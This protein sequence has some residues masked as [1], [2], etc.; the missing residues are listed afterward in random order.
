MPPK[1]N[2]SAST[3]M[4]GDWGVPAA[5]YQ[6]YNGGSPYDN[7][8]GSAIPIRVA[9]KAGG[10]QKLSLDDYLRSQQPTPPSGISDSEVSQVSSGVNT[11]R[12]RAMDST[13]SLSSLN[14]AL[15][16]L[17]ISPITEL[18]N[19]I[20]TATKL[21]EIREECEK[22]VDMIYEHGASAIHEWDIQQVL[23]TLSKP[24][25]PALIREGSMLLLQILSRKFAGRTPYEAYF[26]DLFAPA[27][28]LLADKENTVKRSAQASI[29]SLYGMFPVEAYSSVLLTM[30]LKYL[31]SSAKWQSKV[32]ALKTI[33]K[34]LQEAP[35]DLLESRFVDAIPVLTDMATDFKPE[36]AKVGYKS[37]NDFVKVLDNLDL[38][39]RYDLIV[40]TL[41]DPQKVPNC[42]RSLS[43]VTFVAEVT[44]PALALLVPILDKSFKLSSSSQ[45]QLRQTVMVTEN[46][47]RLVNNKFEIE[48]YI[49][50]LLP[51]V[52]RVVETASLPEVREL[53][54]KAL[55]VI[56]DA[57]AEQSDGKFHGRLSL[58]KAEEYLT[59]IKPKINDAVIYDYLV[60]ILLTD[61]NV[62]DWTRLTEY[63]SMS[64]GNFLDEDA[65]NTFVDK[66]IHKLRELFTPNVFDDSQ[67][68]GVV[69][70]N[71]DFSL[72][73]GTRLLLNKTNLR[74]VKGHRYGLCGRNGVGKSTL[75]RAIANGQLEGFPDK[76]EVRTCFVE[77]KLQGEEADMNL[78]DFI[79]SDPELKDASKEEIASALE[80]VGF[81]SERRNQQVG[82]LSGGW[83]MKLELARAMLMKADVLLL[84]EPTNH[85]DVTNVKWLEDYLVQHTNITS[86]IVS[87]DSRFLDT[88]CTDV[89]HYENKKLVYYKGNLSEFV[90]VKPEGKSYY[91]L[92]D[93]NVKMA[94]PPPGI[95]TGV[96]SNTR[97]VAR[98]SNVTFKYPSAEKP[99]LKNVSC[100]LSLSSRVAI[101]G[102]NGAGKSTL[103]KLLTGE[104]VPNE[105]TVEKHPNLRIGYIAQHALQHVN[106]HKEKTANQYLQWRYQFGDDREVLLKESRKIS[107]DSERQMLEKEIDIGD[108]RGKRQ[109]EAIVGRQKLKK[110]FQY[111]IKWKWW[112]PKYN[113]WVPREKLIAEGF[114]P[115]VQ[116]FDDHE[117]SREGLGYR[118]LTP[119]VIRKHF[120][121]V[122]LDGDIADH[123]PMGSLSGG[124]LVKVVIAG[125]MWNNPH[126]L[127][128]DEPT[129]YLDRDSLGGLAVA[130]REWSGGVVMISHNSEFVGALCPEQWIVEN[131]EMVK[132]G[133]TEIDQ[134]KFEDNGGESAQS[135]AAAEM[136]NKPAPLKKKDDDDSPA[137]IKVR[138]RKKKMTR[139]EKKAQE[140]RRRLRHLEWLSSPKGTPKP[141]DTDEEE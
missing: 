45:E 7:S 37:L 93:S 96:K 116:K 107:S 58:E 94:F 131:G 112:L 136:V 24:K 6:G 127:V 16:K 65:K 18:L 135:R 3:F 22:I 47:T 31:K 92:T 78:V 140:E 28:D 90:K 50:I 79:A 126:L 129:N 64:L 87:H 20:Q 53:A 101:L 42:I 25:N 39:P 10:K 84:D 11:P 74:L 83:K 60:K 4:P 46:L 141:V 8:T 72:A 130:I 61:S 125:A 51:G 133:V 40:Q 62:N 14:S 54:T 108:G 38:Q 48:H 89:I 95:L 102:P 134:S 121:D 103:I 132:K 86:L 119:S 88:V 21:S 113:S 56:E 63:L 104:L 33:D 81:N 137:N 100:S 124:Q 120:E 99:S 43:S 41:A 110:S 17:Q 2:P 12:G 66:T 138:T 32:G 91:T 114:E 57:Q 118:D 55:R 9:K 35:A 59:E 139:N 34:I 122:G 23:V 5:G 85:L 44:E 115:L 27:F 19:S 109:V 70:V 13:T 97:A 68:D 123:T 71:A 76:S 49:P 80:E 73:Y 52:K 29:D 75:M 30:L 77:H 69:I 1:F 128:L 36:L 106:E 105:G 98:M 26:V 15:Q 82:S 117:A 111:E 67:D